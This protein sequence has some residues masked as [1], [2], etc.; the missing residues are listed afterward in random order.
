MP[1]STP[2][3]FD[4]R[5]LRIATVALRIVVI[6]MWVALIA[7]AVAIPAIWFYRET[8][9][10][11]AAQEGLK[12]I[13]NF[14]PLLTMVM[15]GAGGLVFLGIQFMRKLLA[16]VATVPDD[17][18]VPENAA[19]LRTMAWLMLAIEVGSFV[20]HLG[21]RNLV[22]EQRAGMEVSVTGLIAVLAL[23]VLARVFTRGTEMRDEIE[24]TV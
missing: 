3:R 8:I 18:F 13:P 2:S 24:G 11:E 22:P 10:G 9:L 4:D 12:L 14:L 16:I 19:R 21:A 15:L 23:F 1:S 20:L 6:I 17:P 7:V 5:V